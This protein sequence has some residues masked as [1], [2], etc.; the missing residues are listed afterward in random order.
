MR[1]FFGSH[2]E[3]K[4]KGDEK[5]TNETGKTDPAPLPAAAAPKSEKV[6]F[7]FLTHQSLIIYIAKIIFRFVAY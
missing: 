7:R 2:E 3:D 6:Y 5:S 1:H 4:I